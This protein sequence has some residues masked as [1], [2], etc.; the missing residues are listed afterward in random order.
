MTLTI[1]PQSMMA[2]REARRTRLSAEVKKT[3]GMKR[4][5]DKRDVLIFVCLKVTKQ[6]WVAFGRGIQGHRDTVSHGLR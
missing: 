4:I 6:V 1:I 5:W 2:V 3:W